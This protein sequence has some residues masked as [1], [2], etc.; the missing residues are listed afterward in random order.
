MV[1]SAPKRSFRERFVAAVWATHSRSPRIRES[2]NKV[3]GELRDGARGL[4]VGA[5][6]TALHPAVVNLDIVPGPAIDVCAAAGSLPFPDEAFD[7][8]MSQE[9]V[10]HVPDPFQALR[11]MRRVLRRGGTLYFQVPFIIGYHPGPTDFWRFTKEGVSEIVSQAGFERPEVIVAVGPGTGFHRIAVEFFAT[12][13]SAL[14]AGLYFPVKA[15][16]AILLYP[17]KWLDPVLNR[18]SQADRIPGGYLVICK[19]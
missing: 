3:L 15:V 17:I 8:V 12:F 16:T 18:S 11:E 10:E 9:V 1:K 6:P 14:W 13:A 19:R 5:G 2:V 7:L 4:N